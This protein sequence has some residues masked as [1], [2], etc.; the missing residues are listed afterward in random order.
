MRQR[1][2]GSSANSVPHSHDIDSE[3]QSQISIY[4]ARGLLI[5]SQTGPI[6]IVGSGSE[7]HTL[8]QY[9]L[10]NTKNIYMGQIQSET[11]YY[12]PNPPAP[13]PFTTPNTTIQDPEFK[14]CPSNQTTIFGANI[15][16]VGSP[17]GACGMAWALRV[18]DSSNVAVYG[19]GLYSFFN[20]YNTTC[21]NGP[22]G[23]NKCQARITEIK[24]T[25]EDVVLYDYTTIGSR[26]MVN[27]ESTEV[28]LAKDNP[29]VYGD[30]LALFMT[31]ETSGATSNDTSDP[32][33]LLSIVVDI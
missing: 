20:N 3:A 14:N 8:Y 15:T 29:N 23:P 4:A 17:A 5:E 33:A 24:G 13:Y 27:V 1:Q 12:Q 32:T 16:S 30:T 9:Q 31:G 26:S 25:A 21:S 7:H 6:W 28:A 19:A 10:L 2:L 22:L 11:P 18:I